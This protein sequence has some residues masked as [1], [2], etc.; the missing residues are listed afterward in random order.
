MKAKD[1]SPEDEVSLFYHSDHFNYSYTKT[2]RLNSNVLVSSYQ[3]INDSDNDLPAFW[4]MHCLVNLTPK[5]RFIFP[6]SVKTVRNVHAGE[7]LSVQ[8]GLYTFP[9]AIDQ[10]KERRLDGVPPAGMTKYYVE[11]VCPEGEVGYDYPETGTKLR[12]HYDRKKLPYLGLWITNGG[13]R[14][15]KNA[16]L[17]PSS[18]FYDGLNNCQRVN[19]EVP[20]L[21]PKEGYCFEIS[22]NVDSL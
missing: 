5:M 9:A 16:A 20:L 7:W 2:F 17:E 22:I 19:G 13:Y 4:T 3:I 21:R 18:G 12:L 11:G 15:E 14:G 6:A 1:T 10:G 8:D